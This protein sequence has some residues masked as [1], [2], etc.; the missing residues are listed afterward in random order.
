MFGPILGGATLLA[1]SAFAVACGNSSP[2]SGFPGGG[3]SSGSEAGSGSGGS[4]GVG[5]GS[6]SSSGGSFGTTDGSTHADANGDACSANLTGRLRDFVNKP[7]FM[8]S[9]ALDQDF[10]NAI[11]DDRGIVATDLGPTGKPVYAHPSGSTPTTHGQMLFDY[12]YRDT[13]GI[14]I[15]YDYT[16]NLT[17]LGGGV[18]T[19]N[20][21]EFFPLDGRGWN[22]DYVADDGNMHNFSFTFELHTTFEYM[23]GEVFTFI[24]DDDVFVFIAK[25]LVVD[26]GG[27]HPAETKSISLDTLVTDDAAAT[28][29]PLA[30]GTTYPL[31]IFYNERH[32]VASH[33]RMDTSIVFNNCQPIII[34]Q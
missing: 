33:F 32:T 1:A 20:D 29:V 27:V 11:G 16:I 30:K 23:G 4:S 8:P 25:K 28:P 3:S 5:G 6:G 15:P 7:G 12:W 24:G 19:F 14:N 21:Q 9:S 22:D 13:S 18:S 34:P 10:E 31:D 26:L 17:P 2:N